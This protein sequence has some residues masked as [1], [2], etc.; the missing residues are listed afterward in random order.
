MFG[1]PTPQRQRAPTKNAS[2]QGAALTPLLQEG[3][4]RRSFYLLFKIRD[5]GMLEKLLLDVL[6]TV[7]PKVALDTEDPAQQ[8]EQRK[9]IV[10]CSDEDTALVVTLLTPV[11]TTFSKAKNA[12]EFKLHDK[13]GSDDAKLTIAAAGGR[14]A[15]LGSIWNSTA[16]HALKSEF[17]CVTEDLPRTVRSKNSNDDDDSA[18]DPPDGAV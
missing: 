1:R 18:T 4:T 13:D 15:T 14:R 2:K 12:K 6:L 16:Q 9:K 11:Y 7:S 5:E 3:F 10:E 17:Y 8:R